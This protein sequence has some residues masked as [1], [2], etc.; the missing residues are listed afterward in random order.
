MNRYLRDALLLLMISSCRSTNVQDSSGIL[1]AKDLIDYKNYSGSIVCHPGSVI[2]ANSIDDVQKAV[3]DA[4]AQHKTIRALS[5]TAPRSYSPVICPEDGDIILNVQALNKIISVNNSA[6][7]AVVQPGILISELQDQLSPKGFTFPV[8]PDYNGVSIAGGMATGAHHSSLQFATEIADWVE[9]VKIVDGAGELRTLSGEQLDTARVH[10][11]LLGVIVE[12]KVRIIPQHKVKYGFEKL[13]DD[14]LE[15][16]LESLVR[17]H[18]Y[19]R[20]LW[21]PSKKKFILDHFD[22]VPMSTPGESTNNLWTSTPDISAL[23]DIPVGALNVGQVVQC[24]AES[25][26]L[27]TYKGPFKVVDS[28]KNAPVGLSHKMIAGNCPPGK[29]SWDF[30]VKT[31]TVEVGI[32]LD[33]AQDWIRD[34]RKMFAARRACFPVLGIYLRFSAASKSALG[35][36]SG[37][38]TVVFEIH[39]P[40]TSSPSIEPSSDVYDEMVQMTLAK[41]DGRPHWGKNSLPYFLDLG[42]KQYPQWD[43]FE[44]LRSE[45]DPNGVFTSPFWKAI[46]SRASAPRVARCAVSKQCICQQDSD[47][48]SDAICIPGAFFKEARVCKRD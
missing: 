26:R 28:E 15:Q 19:A 1:Q 32:A 4:N 33:R 11:G 46:R 8:T 23:G 38:D 7:T 2:Q 40:Q 34:V 30:G 42:P 5:L 16:D 22:T 21:F 29:C 35:E 14:R 17:A 47:C 9:E 25:L 44:Q 27:N 6:R 31:R 43:K 41:Y 36:A 18:E 48:G 3:R 37:R 45:L 20:I 12:L 24:S 13:A 39:I 10:L